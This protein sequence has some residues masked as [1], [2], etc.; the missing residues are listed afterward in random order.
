ME[1]L[2][3]EINDF[4]QK[5]GAGAGLLVLCGAAC[6]AIGN[7]SAPVSWGVPEVGGRWFQR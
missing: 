5:Q 7:C 2:G 1:A 6:K 4:K 3:Y